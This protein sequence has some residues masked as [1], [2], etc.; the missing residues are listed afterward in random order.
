MSAYRKNI[1]VGLV[2]VGALI[3]LSW[4]ILQFSGNVA[5]IFV[6]KQIPVQF[7]CERGDGVSD[8]SAVSFRGVVVGRITAAHLADDDKQVV[9]EGLIDSKPPLPENVQGVIRSVGL[10]GGIASINLEV[11]GTPVAGK[12]I[13]PGQVIKTRYVGNDLLPPEFRDLAIE[14]KETTAQIRTSGLVKHI[15]LVVTKTTEVVDSL[16]KLV[17]DQKVQAD[18]KQSVADL[19]DV[20]ANAK[21]ISANANVTL[22]STQEHVDEMSRRIGDR[23]IEV[24]KVLKSTQELIDKINTGN[25]TAGKLINDGRLYENLVN[26]SNELNVTIKDLRRLIEQWEEEGFHI[27][28]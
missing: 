26:T 25:G 13:H 9:I 21:Q 28:L 6:A 12:N 11:V 15:D 20:M 5:G 18:L 22:K 3:I 23:L 10:V 19:R 16:Q 8:G 27:K 4:M 7:L 14:L 24:A 1:M 2:M 17:G